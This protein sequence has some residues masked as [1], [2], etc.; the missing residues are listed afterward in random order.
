VSGD[1]GHNATSISDIPTCFGLSEG[2]SIKKVVKIEIVGL[3]IV[4]HPPD[5]VCKAALTVAEQQL[6][7]TIS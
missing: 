1:I 7:R 2:R 3:R 6:L 4:S 5:K